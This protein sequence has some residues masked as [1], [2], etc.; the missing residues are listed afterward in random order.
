MQSGLYVS[1][2]GQVALERRLETIANNIANMNTAGFRADGVSF[3]AELAKAGEQQVAFASAG[4]TYITRGAGPLAK[5]DNPLDLAIQGD[6]WFGIQTPNGIAYTR[7]GRMQMT[8]TGAL[9]TVNGYQVLDAGGAPIG[10][11]P[12]AGPPTISADGMIT[13]D[14]KQ[15]SAVGLFSI[16][17]DAKLTRTV[18]SGVIPDKPAN[19]ILDFTQNGVVQGS[20]EGSNVNPIMEMTKLITVTRNFDSLSA[21]MSQSESSLQDA[22]K[23]LGGAT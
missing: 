4:D 8:E 20:V 21:A 14:G 11:D 2:S 5:T 12:N 13:Q 6:G 23:T 22:I 1:L 18:N 10:L 3:S 15:I 19:P 9:Q 7:D 16:P 17:D